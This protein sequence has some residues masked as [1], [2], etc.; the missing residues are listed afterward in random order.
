MIEDGFQRQLW[1][2]ADRHVC[3]HARV[4]IHTLSYPTQT[5]V[6]AP[7]GPTINPNEGSSSRYLMMAFKFQC[8]EEQANEIHV[9]T[10]PETT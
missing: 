3:M 8:V 9:V 10:V 1:A 4:H 5:C 7:K 6:R 2:S